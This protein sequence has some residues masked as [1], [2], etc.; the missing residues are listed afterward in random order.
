MGP[1]LGYLI[2]PVTL[3]WRQVVFPSPRRCIVNSFLINSGIL[4][5]VPLLSA[6]SLV[7]ACA[8]LVCCLSPWAHSTL[9]LWCRKLW[10]PRSHPPPLAL[11]VSLTPLLDRPLSLEDV[12][13][14]LPS[15][16]VLAFHQHTKLS[17]AVM[18]LETPCGCES[19]ARQPMFFTTLTVVR[20]VG[21][22]LEKTLPVVCLIQF[23]HVQQY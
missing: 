10:S 15:V 22:A 21:L 7:W 8:G 1:A 3:H 12:L 6:E 19:S 16:S 14:N 4:C 5:P 20:S 2:Y 18:S 9:A 23:Q 17:A 13:L 11:T